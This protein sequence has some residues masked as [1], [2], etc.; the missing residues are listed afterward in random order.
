MA[1]A[2]TSVLLITLMLSFIRGS[3]EVGRWIEDRD[4]NRF[5]NQ[6]LA[7]YVYEHMRP[8]Q[9][10]AGMRVLV[11]QA[12]TKH[13]GGKIVNLGFIV[14][15]GVE[16]LEKCITTVF[17]PQGGVPEGRLSITKF[18]CRRSF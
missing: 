10:T 7:R 4:P 5:E 3:F 11:T 12:R 13:E 15:Q 6:A 18:W 14:Y 8:R 1:T 17:T 2:E 16:M 9:S